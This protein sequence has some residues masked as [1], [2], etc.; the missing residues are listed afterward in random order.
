M[1]IS[2]TYFGPQDVDP[3]TLLTF[4]NGLPGFEH[5]T[6][7]KLFHEDGR[8]TVFWLQSVDDPELALSIADPALF[9]LAYELPLDD[10]ELELLDLKDPND[11]V[12]MIVLAQAPAGEALPNSNIRANLKAPLV[13]NGRNRVG[14]QKIID[15]IEQTTLLR[16]K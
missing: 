5:A 4:P 16:A 12:V 15:A 1:K 8:P 2:T 10:A 14:M 6:S 11:V 7:F 13:I 9:N 3:D